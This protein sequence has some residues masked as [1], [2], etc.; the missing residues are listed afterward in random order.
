MKDKRTGEASA[1]Q[2]DPE[3][4]DQLLAK[5]KHYCQLS[6]NTD[7]QVGFTAK[8]EMCQVCEQTNENPVS[9]DLDQITNHVDAVFNCS[10]KSGLEAAGVFSCSHR[11]TGFATTNGGQVITDQTSS[12]M[13]VMLFNGDEFKSGWASQ[14]STSAE[15][16]QS[17]RLVKEAFQKVSIPNRIGSFSQENIQRYLISMPA[18][19]FSPYS[20]RIVFRDQVFTKVERFLWTTWVKHDFILW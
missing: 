13:N 7:T 6:T 1:N 8:N 3:T 12:R 17:D 4:I 14:A 19:K 18:Q 10:K 16:I 20:L 9:M 15:K 2:I 11:R 5:A